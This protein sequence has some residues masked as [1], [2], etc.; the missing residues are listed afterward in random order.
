MRYGT[1]SAATKRKNVVPDNSGLSNVSGEIAGP[2]RDMPIRSGY[3][4]LFNPGES[5]LLDRSQSLGGDRVTVSSDAVELGFRYA[6]QR[7]RETG[8]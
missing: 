5:R 6:A 4:A 8:C 3:P 1:S 7:R 2:D